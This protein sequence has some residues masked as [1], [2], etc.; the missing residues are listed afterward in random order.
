MRCH[1]LYPIGYGAKFATCRPRRKTEG[2]EPPQ[3]HLMTFNDTCT[4]FQQGSPRHLACKVTQGAQP[5]DRFSARGPA[6]M[7][8]AAAAEDIQVPQ[9]KLS[10]EISTIPDLWREWT[11]GLADLHS[12]KELDRR[13]RSK[14]RPRGEA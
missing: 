9:Y 2:D 1:R 7:K 11:V 12:V 10:L 14:W 3:L 4:P 8:A 5:K 6:P 13:Y